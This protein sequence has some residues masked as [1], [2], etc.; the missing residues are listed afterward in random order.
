MSLQCRVKEISLC[1]KD[2]RSGETAIKL[3]HIYRNM[4]TS[5]THSNKSSSNNLADWQKKLTTWLEHALSAYSSAD[6]LRPP[7]VDVPCKLAQVHIEQGNFM[8]ALTILSGLRNRQSAD[9][10]GSY[11]LPL[12][13][14]DMNASDGIEGLALIRRTWPSAGYVNTQQYATGKSDAFK[15]Y[16]SAGSKSCAELSRRMKQRTK[17][18]WESTNDHP[19]DYWRRPVIREGLFGKRTLRLRQ[20]RDQDLKMTIYYYRKMRSPK[21]QTRPR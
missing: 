9:M 18:L 10:E 14:F 21:L 6:N 5:Y 1:G 7:G 11:P 17:Q 3:V 16:V 20:Y 12:L 13:A 2:Q 8:N 19:T 15:H 4:I